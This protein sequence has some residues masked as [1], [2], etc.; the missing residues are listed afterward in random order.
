[1]GIVP[2]RTSIM[3]IGAARSDGRMNPPCLPTRKAMAANAVLREGA[4]ARISVGS[5]NLL[6]ELTSMINPKSPT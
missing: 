4:G 5:A 1:M 6:V 2:A 3:R